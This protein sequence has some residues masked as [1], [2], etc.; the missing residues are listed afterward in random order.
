MN[1]NINNQK[2]P[3]YEARKRAYYEK[4]QREAAAAAKKKRYAP[5]Y[6]AVVA[7]TLLI[8]ICIGAAIVT[9][10]LYNG[11]KPISS[12]TLRLDGERTELKTA[13]DGTILINLDLL[14]DM[15]DLQKTGSAAEPKYTAAGG[16]AITFS[17]DSKTANV[18]AAGT[19]DPFSV[20][21]NI[22]A[23]AS[24]SG[25][26]VSLDTVSSVF[27]GITVT[28]DG[29]TVK[30]ARREIVGKAGQ[31]EPV[32]ILNKST[33]P[34]SRVLRL[35][36]I[37]REYEQY[38]DPADRD[39][40]LTLVNK[41]NPISKD[42]VPTDLVELPAEIK[43]GNINCSQMRLYA[44]KA[45]EAMIKEIEAEF[46]VDNLANRIFAQSGYRTYEYQLNNFNK[47]IE[48]EMAA[49]PDLTYDEAREL[50][51]KYSALP[52]CS[53]HRTGLAIDL[54]DTRVGE[55]DNPFTNAYWTKWL[56]T[57]AWKFGFILRYPES[58]DEV[59][60]ITGYQYESWHFRYVG[61]YHAERI[62]AAGLTLEEYLENMN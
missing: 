54:I 52:E 39:A 47:Y 61:R 24:S 40:Y 19:K 59:H 41:E 13:E 27:S 26:M 45:L 6:I 57:N 10:V 21:M 50:A 51:L 43:N 18:I 29:A 31:Y 55:L 17:H 1:N 2:D 53:E 49:D 42:Y 5:Y 62:S 44:A 15:L 8:I 34:I 58:E 30:I 3:Q 25:C 32:T 28:V 16:D 36:N 12:Y 22:A 48:A 4:K 37:M 20:K 9:S 23:E 7:I 11:T 46:K 35:T 38:L 56:E 60:P 33:D 14:C